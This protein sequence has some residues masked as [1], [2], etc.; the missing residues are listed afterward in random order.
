MMITHESF[1][2]RKGVI[3]FFFTHLFFNKF[4]GFDYTINWSIILVSKNN[5]IEKIG[6]NKQGIKIGSTIL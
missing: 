6:V 5:S 2:Y 1:Y 4:D 3:P